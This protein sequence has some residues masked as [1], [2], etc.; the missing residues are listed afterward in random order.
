MQDPHDT[1]AIS[2]LPPPTVQYNTVQYN[3]VRLGTYLHKDFTRARQRRGAASFTAEA[4]HANFT[5]RCN[6]QAHGIFNHGHRTTIHRDRFTLFQL[7][8]DGCTA[9]CDKQNTILLATDLL[10]KASET[11][12]AAGLQRAVEITPCKNEDD[13]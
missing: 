10:A 11:C 1:V 7:F 9:G 13:T 3:T 5:I 8:K 12:A 4:T 6:S 2:Q